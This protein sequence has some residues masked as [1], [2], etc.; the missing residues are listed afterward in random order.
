MASTMTL[1]DKN[2]KFF[3]HKLPQCLPSILE[4]HIVIVNH[5]LPKTAINH[6]KD[7]TKEGMLKKKKKSSTR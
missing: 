5:I 2:S 1:K 4:Q 6:K 7:K 3:W